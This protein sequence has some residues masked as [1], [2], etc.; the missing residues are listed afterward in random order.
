MLNICHWFA[1]ELIISLQCNRSYCIEVGF[2][3]LH[4]SVV[5]FFWLYCNCATL[6]SRNITTRDVYAL[7]QTH[8]KGNQLFDALPL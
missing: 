5:C 8:Q 7:Q 2:A 1:Q 4:M 6:F 3:H